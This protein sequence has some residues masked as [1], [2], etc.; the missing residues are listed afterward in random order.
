MKYLKITRN[1]KNIFFD[2][3]G[4]IVDSNKSKEI[5]IEIAIK[6]NC[7]KLRKI[8]DSILF[9]NKY[10][11]V[12]RQEKL[13]KFFEKKTVDNIMLDYEKLCN[14]FYDLSVPTKGA[15]NF[16]EKIYK[17]SE[18]TNLYILSGGEK[19]EIERFL[20]RNNMLHFFKDILSSEDSKTNHLKKKSSSKDDIFFGDSFSDFKAA[21]NTLIQFIYVYG[22]KSDKSC[23]SK[24]DKKNINHQ[25]KN[26][27]ELK[28][29]QS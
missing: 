7:K 15:L 29:E 22:Y 13:Q 1:T 17:F 14:E 18:K 2:F 10:A 28:I 4:V 9:F 20:C 26:F 12:G 16:I 3:D 25:I 23:I 19:K 6:K 24:S 21:K 8:K 5:N 27:S 11:G